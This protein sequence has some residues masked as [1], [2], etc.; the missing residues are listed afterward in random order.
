MKRSEIQQAID[1][2][3]DFLGRSQLALP[4]FANWDIQEWK[5]HFYERWSD[6]SESFP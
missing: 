6:S 1:W 2:A 3:K 5:A 4:M